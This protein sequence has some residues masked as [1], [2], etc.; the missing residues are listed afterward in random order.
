MGKVI[1]QDRNPVADHAYASLSRVAAHRQQ[2]E[3]NLEY[4]RASAAAARVVFKPGHRYY[5]EGCAV[6]ANALM[7]QAERCVDEA[8]KTKDAAIAKKAFGYLDELAADKDFASDVKSASGWLD[9]LRGR[10][11]KLEPATHDEGKA[12]ITRGIEALK[13]KEKPTAED[14]RRLKKAE[15]M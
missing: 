4:A 15:A 1:Y 6:L 11:L 7:Q 14:A 13:K 9:C 2:W 8:W 10:V 12:L 3:K 5:R